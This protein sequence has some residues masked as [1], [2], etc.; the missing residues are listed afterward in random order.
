MLTLATTWQNCL[1]KEMWP[2]SWGTRPS[3]SWVA[4][5]PSYTP[6]TPHAPWASSPQGHGW[7][8]CPQGWPVSLCLGWPSS[9]GWCGH[10]PSPCSKDYP[11]TPGQ[12]SNQDSI[13][14]SWSSFHVQH[15]LRKVS[16]SWQTSSQSSWM[17]DRSS[18]N[19]FIWI[20]IF[21]HTEIIYRFF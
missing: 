10:M 8:C 17:L 7:A 11:Q 13:Y 12:I 20:L 19:N 14:Q 4:L 15:P 1:T 9:W 5:S 21:S 3:Y 18:L 2:H 6:P 16:V